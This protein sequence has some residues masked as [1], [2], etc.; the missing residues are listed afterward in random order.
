VDRSHSTSDKEYLVIGVNGLQRDAYS[1]GLRQRTELAILEMLRRRS[2]RP[3]TGL[4]DQL[5]E[6][7][8]A[9]TKLAICQA[10]ARADPQG[11]VRRL[12][13][14]AEL[15]DPAGAQRL[16]ALRTRIAANL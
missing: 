9:E 8:S 13:R 4:F 10:T 2:S 11:A 7:G 12:T 3:D 16:H 5:F 14:L 1:I 15:A 6:W